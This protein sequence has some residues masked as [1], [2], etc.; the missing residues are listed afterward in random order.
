MGGWLIVRLSTS[1]HEVNTCEFYQER[2]LAMQDLLDSFRVQAAAVG[3]C[4]R[5]RRFPPMPSAESPGCP[6]SMDAES[7]PDESPP[8]TAYTATDMK[9]L[10]LRHVHGMQ[11]VLQVHQACVSVVL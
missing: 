9:F 11:G 3:L 1:N 7:P 4:I 5:P 2:Q 8:P 6:P 10:Q